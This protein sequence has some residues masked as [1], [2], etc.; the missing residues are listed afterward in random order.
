M[1]AFAAPADAGEEGHGPAPTGH[2]VDIEDHLDVL[3]GALGTASSCVE[4]DQRFLGYPKNSSKFSTAVKS[5]SFPTVLG[6]SVLAPRVL[7]DW[8]EIPQIFVPKHSS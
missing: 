7:D 6:P 2:A 5:N 3:E 1:E 8:R 4:S